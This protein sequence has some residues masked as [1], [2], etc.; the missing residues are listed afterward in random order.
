[1]SLFSSIQISLLKDVATSRSEQLE[2]A[3]LQPYA[4]YLYDIIV[5]E[6][7]RDSALI[8]SDLYKA[9]HTT[10]TPDEITVPFW[11]FD[12]CYPVPETH[13]PH[14]HDSYIG[15]S[16]SSGDGFGSWTLP[17]VSLDVLFRKTDLCTRLSAFLAP[18]NIWVHPVH[19]TLTFSDPDL[20]VWQ[21]ELVIS[22][23]PSG[24]A[25]DYLER[26][27][28]VKAKYLT[29]Y[30][31]RPLEEGECIERSGNVGRTAPRTPEFPAP[32]PASPPLLPIKRPFTLVADS[33][34]DEPVSP[35]CFCRSCTD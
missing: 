3:A 30:T 16:D 9:A 18:N 33:D 21:N 5:E 29:S 19:T 6:V 31:P 10:D 15:V 14:R 11:R 20:D 27:E 34:D 2:T 26:I 7:K 25:P 4:D 23:Y 13:D 8:F 24:L 17:P 22:F 32:M 12:A 35:P 28:A 1:M